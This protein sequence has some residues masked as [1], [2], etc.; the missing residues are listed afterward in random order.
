MYVYL[1]ETKYTLRFCDYKQQIGDLFH[2]EL[3]IFENRINNISFLNFL[4]IPSNL[5]QFVHLRQIHIVISRKQKPTMAPTKTFKPRQHAIH[6]STIA[7]SISWTLKSQQLAKI[8]RQGQKKTGTI[9]KKS[10]ML[11]NP[12]KISNIF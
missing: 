9:P 1:C 8:G 7:L 2:I 11:A 6:A 3:V 5:N 10:Q 4:R 12:S